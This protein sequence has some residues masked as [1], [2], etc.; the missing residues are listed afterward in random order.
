MEA[1]P[2]NRLMTSCSASWEQVISS[3][4]EDG[5]RKADYVSLMM[6]LPSRWIP[7]IT[8]VAGPCGRGG[9]E[10]ASCLITPVGAHG[11]NWEDGS[12]QCCWKEN[13]D[14]VCVCVF[15]NNSPFSNPYHRSPCRQAG[16]SHWLL[17][18]AG[19]QEGQKDMNPQCYTYRGTLA[20]IRDT[21]GFRLICALMLLCLIP[22]R[23]TRRD[24]QTN[25]RVIFFLMYFE[26]FF[27][28]SIVH[29][30]RGDLSCSFIPVFSYWV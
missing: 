8:P 1:S 15:L 11:S 13:L 14:F 2:L 27:F 10:Y 19:A 12:N 6:A 29:I 17:N 18:R 22:H 5:R 3:P 7:Q 26:L 30:I 9:N 23:E 28:S 16:L 24:V 21:L 4:T 25:R 20:V